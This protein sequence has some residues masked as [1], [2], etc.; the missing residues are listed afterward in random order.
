[1]LSASG[2]EVSILNRS[3]PQSGRPEE[4][5]Q[6]FFDLVHHQID[7]VKSKGL[8]VMGDFNARMHGRLRGEKT[9][10]GPL[11]F[12]RGLAAIGDDSSNRQM[13]VDLCVANDLLVATT[14]FQHPH[15]Q[16]ASYKVPGTKQLLA[17]SDSWNSAEFAQLD[18]CL[19][20]VRWPNAS[21][22]VYN[23]PRANLDSDHFPLHVHIVAKLGAKPKDSKRTR[24]AFDS[25]TPEQ[26][27]S[28]NRE[29]DRK[30]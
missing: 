30:L 23:K 6:G 22:N 16:Q 9:V 19:M 18:F 24:W 13:L 5:R 26:V 20:L 1:M 10:L 2:E 4:E 21:H 14:W 17:G 12:G 15:G 28:M 27:A 25:A 3:A 8:F 11:L 29:I 7:L